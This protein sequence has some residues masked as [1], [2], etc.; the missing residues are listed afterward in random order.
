MQSELSHVEERDILI[1]VEDLKCLA[2]KRAI[3][4]AGRMQDAGGSICT[5]RAVGQIC[6][7]FI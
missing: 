7:V 2:D 4:D 1:A 6:V 5:S 3:S